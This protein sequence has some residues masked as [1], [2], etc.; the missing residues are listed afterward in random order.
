MSLGHGAGTV[1]SGLI[2]HLDAANVKSY[3]S[4]TSTSTWFDLSGN[5]RNVVKAGSQSPTYPQ[6]NSLGYFEFTGGTNGNAFSYFN[7][8]IPGLTSITIDVFHYA[9]ASGGHVIRADNNAY[10]IGP[11]GYTA[12]LSFN[13]IRSNRLDTINTWVNDSLT[14]DGNILIGYRNGVQYST[15]T[16]VSTAT[17]AASTARIGTRSDLFTAH[18]VGNIA[19]IKIYNRALSAIEISQ[20]FEAS[21]GRYRI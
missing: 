20:N 15:A 8:D 21:R 4:L 11:D 1:L 2:L 19:T 18:Y 13:D 7:A 17:I 16:R 14:F 5:N 12:G 3:N 10:Q 9:T 6:W